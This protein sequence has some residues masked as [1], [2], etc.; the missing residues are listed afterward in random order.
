[1]TSDDEGQVVLLIVGFAVMAALLVAVVANVSRVFLYERSLAAA[2]DGAA[3]AA[4]SALEEPA[5]YDRSRG[6]RDRLPLD[7]VRAEARVAAYAQDTELPRRFRGFGYSVAVAADTATVTFSA[8]VDLPFVGAVVPEYAGGVPI[9][10][11]AS[12]RSPLR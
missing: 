8:R 7:P 11:T 6:L 3:V 10:V 9:T 1:M 5:V 2:A 4:S 12:A